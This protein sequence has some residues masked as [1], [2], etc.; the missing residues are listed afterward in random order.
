MP[1]EIVL[2]PVT[3]EDIPRIVQIEQETYSL[4]WS[5]DTFRDALTRDYYCFLKASAGETIAG[6][7]GY[8]RSFETADITN[9]TVRKEYRRRGIARRMLEALLEK[10]YAQG[11][12]RFSLEVRASNEPAL[13]LYKGLGFRQEGVRKGY[14]ESPR[15]DALILWTPER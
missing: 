3:E 9:V 15:E 14:Y 13:L 10:G 8:L 2:S 12:E 7:C 5:A 4:P 11:V 6:Y 1:D